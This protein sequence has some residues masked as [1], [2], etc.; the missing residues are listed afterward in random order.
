MIDKRLILVLAAAGLLAA[1]GD[2][3]GD[4]TAQ[5]PNEVLEGTIS[6]AMLP[7]DRVRSQAPLEDPEA[8]AA[9]QSQANATTT[10]AAAPTQS[11]DEADYAAESEA[12]T[13]TE[14][15]EDAG[16]A[17]ADEAAEAE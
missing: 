12:E 6:D 2:D 11:A 3:A 9:A 17:A 5:A 4:E 15:E 1:C 8:F 14:T 10:R 7:L 16:E 13:E